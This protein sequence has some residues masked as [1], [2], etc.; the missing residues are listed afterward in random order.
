MSQAGPSTVVE[1]WGEH[2]AFV[3]VDGRITYVPAFGGVQARDT[4]GAGD[5][6]AA[7]L[8]AGFQEGLDWDAS[9]RLGSAVAALKIQHLGARSGLPTREEV[10]RFSR[11]G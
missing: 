2:G 4:T 1:T 6:F 9:A 10:T 5:A 8:V 11:R 7:G 3:L